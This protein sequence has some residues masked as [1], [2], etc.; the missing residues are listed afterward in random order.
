MH[1]LLASN[2]LVCLYCRISANTYLDIALLAI[3]H[4]SIP[5]LRIQHVELSICGKFFIFMRTVKIYIREK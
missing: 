1:S 3:S 4:C 2:E 5:M